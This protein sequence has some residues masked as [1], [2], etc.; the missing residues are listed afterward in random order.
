MVFDAAHDHEAIVAA[1]NGRRVT[2]IVLTHGHNDHINA[3]VPLRDAVTPR[4]C[5]TPPTGCCG[6]WSG[7][8]TRPIVAL[9][10]GETLLAGHE[11]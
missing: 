10:P 1:V 4:S 5:C 6:T 8:T 11:L 3:A 7:P 9:A 2:A